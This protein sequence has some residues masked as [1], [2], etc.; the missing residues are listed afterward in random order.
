MIRSRAKAADAMTRPAQFLSCDWGTSS[1]R[2]RWVERSEL[3]VIREVRNGEGV[4]GVHGRWLESE[5]TSNLEARSLAFGRV[6][7]DAIRE[8]GAGFGGVPSGVPVVISGMASSSVGW[9]ELPYSRTPCGWDGTG[10]RVESME[11]VGVDGGSHP[12]WMVSGLSTGSDI[13]RGEETELMGVLALPEMAKAREGCLVVLPGTHAKHVWVDRGAIADFRTYMT[14]ELLE[15]LSTQSLLKVSVAWPPPALVAGPEAPVY[16]DELRDGV[17]A[18]RN[19]GLARGLF[20]VRVRSVLHPSEP[21]RNAWFL[22]GLVLGAESMDL[23][24]WDP[25]LPIVLAGAAHFSESYRTVFEALGAVDR[26]TVVPP[27]RLLHATIRSH[28]LILQR[29]GT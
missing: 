24:R 29:L 22:A 2:L 5:S 9:R 10:L 27:E 3:S 11:D 14:G 12:V 7:V 26:L 21:G 8:L 4:R 6:L 23:V 18:A 17:V 25:G 28:A 1:F 16:R 13:L 19:L 15:V 20:Q